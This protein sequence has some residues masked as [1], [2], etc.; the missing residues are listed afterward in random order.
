MHDRLVGCL[1]VGVD[2]DDRVLGVARRALQ[3]V[4]KRL[5]RRE[6]ERRLAVDLVA[7]LRVEADVDLARTLLRGIRA[8]LRQRDLQLGD[9]L[10]R[11]RHHQEDQDDEQDVDQR[12]EVDLRIVARPVAAQV[13]LRSLCAKSTSLIA[14]CSISTTSA[15]TLARKWR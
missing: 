9:P 6:R 5:H 4:G 7:P 3:H 8:R 13:H 11:R 12:N 2:D 10:V 14:C 1:R 15:S